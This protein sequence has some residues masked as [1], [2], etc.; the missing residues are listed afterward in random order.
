MKTFSSLP[1]PLCRWIIFVLPW[2]V[3]GQ[4]FFYDFLWDDS[5]L[6]L[7]SNP[8]LVDISLANLRQFWTAPY[9]GMYIPLTYTLWGLLKL[10]SGD[11]SAS[12]RI[13]A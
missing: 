10:W 4:T 13:S 8:Y 7:H 6:H 11:F 9:Q 12:S 1:R 2:L 5:R 3:F